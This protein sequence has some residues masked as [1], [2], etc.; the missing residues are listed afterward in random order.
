MVRIRTVTGFVEFTD[1]KKLPTE[2]YIKI[3]PY[4]VSVLRTVGCAVPITNVG[5][6]T[7]TAHARTQIVAS[8][9]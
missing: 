1:R 9:A 8:I 4:E 7:V 3:R 5:W 6:R 2:K